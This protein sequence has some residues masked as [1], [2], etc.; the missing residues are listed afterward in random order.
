MQ[1]DELNHFR[2]AH[3]LLGGHARIA[4][5]LI[6]K[7]YD[8]IDA[9]C[10]GLDAYSIVLADTYSEHAL[11]YLLFQILTTEMKGTAAGAK[12]ESLRN[13]SLLVNELA[14]KLSLPATELRNRI[15][16]KRW[17]KQC[18]KIRN[19]LTHIF[20]EQPVSNRDSG[21]AISASVAMIANL[22]RLVEKHYEDPTGILFSLLKTVE[23]NHGLDEVQIAQ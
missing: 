14:R 2:T 18:R 11:R 6:S 1:N 4:T 17:D 8:A 7:I 13:I 10:R 16:F 5:M 3:A 21:R 22:I 23:W 20:L 12:V 19:S 9:Q 15:E